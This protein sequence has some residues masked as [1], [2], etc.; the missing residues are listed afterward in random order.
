MIHTLGEYVLYTPNEI[1]AT[2]IKKIH[3]KII[4]DML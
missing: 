2:E 4:W 1:T 3:V